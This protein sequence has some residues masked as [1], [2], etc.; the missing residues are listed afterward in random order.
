[1]LLPVL[2]SVIDIFKVFE[3]CFS[4]LNPGVLW[5]STFTRAATLKGVVTYIP[6][7]IPENISLALVRYVQLLVGF[8]SALI[9]IT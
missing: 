5:R 8:K 2:G 4:V 1:M 9:P 6:Q 3:T 7:T